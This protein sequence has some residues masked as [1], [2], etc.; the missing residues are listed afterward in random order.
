MIYLEVTFHI[1][2]FYKIL[3]IKVANDQDIVKLTGGLVI[4]ITKT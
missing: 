4:S 3:L 2:I 1:K